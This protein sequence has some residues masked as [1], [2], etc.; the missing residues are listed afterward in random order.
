[1]CLQD[2]GL[3]F[4]Q[5][6]HKYFSALHFNVSLTGFP[7]SKFRFHVP[8]PLASFAENLILE[9]DEGR[10]IRNEPQNLYERKVQPCVPQSKVHVKRAELRTGISQGISS[11]TGL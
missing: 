2:A 9:A 4:H 10:A 11:G 1:M 7:D 5:G 8:F 6:T 3:I